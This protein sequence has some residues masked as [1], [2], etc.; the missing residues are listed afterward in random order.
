MSRDE[1]HAIAVAVGLRIAKAR[2]ATG[3]TQKALAG[4]AG[5]SPPTLSRMERG[6]GSAYIASLAAVARS[7]GT[8]ASELLD[9]LG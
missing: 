1:E 7:L 8:T 5:V 4:Q 2:R 6:T 9:G 3:Q